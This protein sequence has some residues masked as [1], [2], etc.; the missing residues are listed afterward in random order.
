MIGYRFL[1]P[2]EDEMSEAAIFYDAACLGL[3]R[4]FLDDIQQRILDH[5]D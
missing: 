1:Y 3:G 5:C 4:D 2:A